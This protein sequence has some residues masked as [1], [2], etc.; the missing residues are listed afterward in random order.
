MM[1]DELEDFLVQMSKQTAP[2]RQFMLMTGSAG[3]SKFNQQVFEG[4]SEFLLKVRRTIAR[5]KLKIMTYLPSDEVTNIRA[6]IDSTEY[7]L[8]M[9][10]LII[11][12]KQN[13]CTIPT[14]ESLL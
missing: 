10:E 4:S 11:E 5:E 12:N 13:G 9:A 2:P 8:T 3:L 6:M 1:I 7:D 14:G